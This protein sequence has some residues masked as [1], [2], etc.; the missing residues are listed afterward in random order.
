VKIE[1]FGVDIRMNEWETKCALN[2]AETCVESRARHRSGRAGGGTDQEGP[3]VT[4]SMADIC[5]NVIGTA[6]MSK[7]CSL[8]WLRLGRVAAPPEVI[9]AVSIQRDY[10][11]IFVGVLDDRRLR[12][13]TGPKLRRT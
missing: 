13:W 3:G 9:A 8:A 6:G 2:L 1:P 11:T 12:G 10:D 5:E 7:A 4:A